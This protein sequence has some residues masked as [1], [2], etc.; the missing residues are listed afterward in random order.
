MYKLLVQFIIN[1]HNNNNFT[2]VG[3][4]NIRN[5]IIRKNTKTISMLKQVVNNEMKKSI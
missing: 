1:L 3:I 2:R 4:I 5:G